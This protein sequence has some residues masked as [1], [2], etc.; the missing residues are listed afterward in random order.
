MLNT[1]QSVYNNTLSGNDIF[2]M[3]Q[4]GASNNGDT[5]SAYLYGGNNIFIDGD[6]YSVLNKNN[7]Q[8]IFIGGSGINTLIMPGKAS[9]Y[10]ITASNSIWNDMAQ[11]GNLSGYII[12]DN[13]KAIN[14]LGVSSIRY[15]EFA[16]KMIKLSDMSTVAVPVITTRSAVY[17]GSSDAL[18]IVD[19]GTTV[20]GGKGTETITLANWNT[21]L[22]NY[23]SLDSIPFSNFIHNVTIDQNVGRIN[24]SLPSFF[25]EFQQAGNTIN[26]YDSTG[27]NLILSGPVQGGSNGTL[28]S[29]GDGTASVLLS[30]GKMTLGGALIS[31]SQ[32]SAVTP[33]LTANVGST[34][35]TT[36]SQVY[37][38]ANDTF[39]VATPGQSVFGNAGKCIVGI[40]GY[41]FTNNVTPL[42]IILDQNVSEIDFRN[43]LSTLSFLQSGNTINV[44]SSNGL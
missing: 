30:A 2:I 7:Y 32:P 27:S 1:D 25:Y 36:T 17:M 10:S 31:S 39:N 37:M 41:D 40:G 29:F 18:N 15:V 3:G 13:T 35:T 20:Y 33:T 43:N 14:T 16:D 11:T 24:L 44:Y 26:V 23:S 12:T 6:K 28:F 19:S 34:A 8:D 42:N 21:L 22:A 4:S 9:N 38:A 5:A